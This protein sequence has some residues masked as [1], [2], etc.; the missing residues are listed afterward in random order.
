[1]KNEFIMQTTEIT[2]NISQ[3]IQNSMK[4]TD[5]ASFELL[6]FFINNKTEFVFLRIF[7]NKIENF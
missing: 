6:V 1:M 7:L 5:N 4:N 3:I 2:K